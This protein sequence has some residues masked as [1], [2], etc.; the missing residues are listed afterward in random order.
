[1]FILVLPSTRVYKIYINLR[2]PKRLKIEEQ[3]F[4]F[5]ARGF[6]GGGVA[7]VQ[8]KISHLAANVRVVFI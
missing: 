5:F 6:V 7:C 1:M 2:L 8:N 3:D 4:G